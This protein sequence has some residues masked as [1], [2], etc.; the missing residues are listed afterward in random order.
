MTKERVPVRRALLSVSDKQGLV[1]LARGLQALGVKIL[2]TGG[3]AKLL[4]EAGLS[5]TEVSAVTGFPEILDGRVKTLHPGIH[6]GILARRDDPGHLEQIRRAGIDPIDLVI[7]NLYPFEATVRQSGVSLAQAIEHI[8]IGGP[9][10]IRSAAKNFADVTVVVDPADYAHLLQEL[11]SQGGTLSRET[12]FSF[13]QKAFAHTAHYDSIISAYFSKRESPMSPPRFPDHFALSAEK[14]QDLR[15]GENPHQR[16]AFYRL[17]AGPGRS[18]ADFRQLGGPDLSYNNL[19]DLQ[20]AASLISE[21]DDPACVV[22]K[23]T[24]PCGVGVGDTL[25]EACARA[26]RADPI[27]IYGG[28]VGF[29]RPV[30]P[31]ALAPLSG[32]LLEILF[33]PAFEPEALEQLR[34]RKKVRTLELPLELPEREAR[35]FEVRSIWGGLLVQDADRIDLNLADLKVVTK[36]EPTGEEMQAL[37]FAWRICKHVKSNAIVLATADQLVGVGAGQMSRVDA[38]RFA[39]ARATANQLTTVGTVAAS[40]AFFPFRDG[41]DVLAE[42]GATAVIQPGGSIRDAELIT[43]ADE[44]GMAMV[45]TGIRHFRH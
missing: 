29:N 31:P 28:I 42:A 9:A 33:A 23:H 39:V 20:S 24:N 15:Y 14:I 38:A 11:E 43:A 4:C 7:V 36:R 10:M 5:V 21:F 37:R 26:K 18:L 35:D 19:L 45:F 3:T 40:D 34:K 1:E 6:A 22:I 2:S 8:D 17:P 30:D 25:A 12:R 32:I 41:L 13:A 27:S 16:A 44:H